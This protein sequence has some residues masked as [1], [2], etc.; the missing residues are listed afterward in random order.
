MKTRTFAIAAATWLTDLRPAFGKDK[1]FYQDELNQMI[2]RDNG[3]VY[4]QSDD[5]FELVA[6]EGI[7]SDE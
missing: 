1:F 2:R 6:N 5:D 7:D 4:F 3:Q